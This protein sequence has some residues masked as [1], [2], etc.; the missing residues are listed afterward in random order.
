M[1]VQARCRLDELGDG[2][3]LRDRRRVHRSARISVGLQ[4]L[5][6]DPIEGLLKHLVTAIG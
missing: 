2:D 4:R 5:V 3:H 6:H 1:I